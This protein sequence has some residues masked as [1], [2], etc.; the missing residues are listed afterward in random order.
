MRTGDCFFPLI[1]M[2]KR[3]ITITGILT[4]TASPLMALAAPEA[5]VDPSASVKVTVQLC[6]T[7]LA[8]RAFS[9]RQ[10]RAHQ[11]WHDM[12]EQQRTTDVAAWKVAHTAFH[13]E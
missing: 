2:M 5:P 11:A 6:Q 8:P 10:E 1:I 7:L 12:H 13:Q 9:I 3:L 4:L